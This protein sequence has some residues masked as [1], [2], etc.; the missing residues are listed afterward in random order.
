M[1]EANYRIEESQRVPAA[2]LRFTAS[3]DVRGGGT[4]AEYVENLKNSSTEP[5]DKW[6][7]G[8]GRT[9]WVTQHINLSE[10]QY[11]ITKYAL[12]SAND[13]ANRDPVAWKLTGS[14]C[15]N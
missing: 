7:T 12:C 4:G 1:I 10:Q 13:C 5:W 6:F 14:N 15:L 8:G 11:Y 3:A 9:A 2:E